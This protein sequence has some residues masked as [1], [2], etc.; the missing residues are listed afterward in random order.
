VVSMGG[1]LPSTP[2]TKNHRYK[3]ISSQEIIELPRD[4][5]DVYSFLYFEIPHCAGAFKMAN[6]KFLGFPEF[7]G[8]KLYFSTV[9]DPLTRFFAARNTQ[10]ETVP[11]GAVG[12][13]Q[14]CCRMISAP[15]IA[16]ICQHSRYHETRANHSFHGSNLL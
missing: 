14:T 16:G 13:T 2:K 12:R 4:S 6:S 8:A 11:R 10:S 9:R 1:R 5:R 15:N 7:M 3:A